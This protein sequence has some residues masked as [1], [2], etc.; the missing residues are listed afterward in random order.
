M[1]NKQADPFITVEP[2]VADPDDDPISRS[3]RVRA[4]ALIIMLY[5][6]MYSD[7]N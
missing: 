5:E 2:P 3:V 7:R 4:L 1:G 6:L